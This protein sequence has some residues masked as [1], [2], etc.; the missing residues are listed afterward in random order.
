MRP[1]GYDTQAVLDCTSRKA[2]ATYKTK[3]KFIILIQPLMWCRVTTIN[4]FHPAVQSQLYMC[5]A[6]PLQAA[7]PIFFRD[8]FVL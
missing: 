2:A 7:G 1:T 4:Y 5:T 3:I 6:A 8:M